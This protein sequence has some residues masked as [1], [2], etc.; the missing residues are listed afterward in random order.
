ILSRHETS[1]T[2]LDQI[3]R[4]LGKYPAAKWHEHEP[5]ETSSREIYHFDKAEVIVSL[6]ADFLG[7]SAAGLKY[8]RDFTNGRRPNSTMNRLYVVESTPTLTGAMAD[9]RLL[10]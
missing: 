7:D 10:M 4:L 8:T 1:P 5:L 9:H 3:R 2:F 6:G